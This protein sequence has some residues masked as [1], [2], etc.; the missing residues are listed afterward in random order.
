MQADEKPKGQNLKKT[1]IVLVENIN[2]EVIKTI[3]YQL[4]SLNG[5]T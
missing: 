3:R 2:F 4:K 5:F 1:Y